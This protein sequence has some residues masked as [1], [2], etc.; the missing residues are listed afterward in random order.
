MVLVRLVHIPKNNNHFEQKSIVNLA[1]L[2][3]R[4]YILFTWKTFTFRFVRRRRLLP[5][6][7]NECSFGYA[8]ERY[9]FW[10]DAETGARAHATMPRRPPATQNRMQTH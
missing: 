2:S 4:L 7:E 10:Q 5:T 9:V 6:I 8:T 3:Q 1:A